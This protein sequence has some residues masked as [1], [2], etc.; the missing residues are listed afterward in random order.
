MHLVDV[1]PDIGSLIVGLKTKISRVMV[2]SVKVYS[3]P[4]VFI[5]N[6]SV[7]FPRIADLHFFKA[8]Y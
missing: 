4:L 6:V 5:V 3:L 2:H 1:L 8:N 7:T